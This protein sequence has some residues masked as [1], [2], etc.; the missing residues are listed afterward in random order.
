MEKSRV[1]IVPRTA[2]VK[3]GKP[4]TVSSSEQLRAHLMKRS[5]K[6]GEW[7]RLSVGHFTI[8]AHEQLRVLCYQCYV[9]DPTSASNAHDA[10]RLRVVPRSIMKELLATTLLSLRTELN[11]DVVANQLM[12]TDWGWQPWPRFMRGHDLPA[13]THGGNGNGKRVVHPYDC[14]QSPAPPLVVPSGNV[15]SSFNAPEEVVTTHGAHDSLSASGLRACKRI[16]IENA[17]KTVV[18]VVDDPTSPHVL[19]LERA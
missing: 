11:A 9:H 17:S 6:K 3:V 2:I 13:P 15:R 14:N 19:I 8:V 1:H 4:L 16:R 18:V 10:F 7:P 12:P 5:A